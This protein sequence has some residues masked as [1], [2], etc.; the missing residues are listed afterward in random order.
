MAGMGRNVFIFQNVSV[1]ETTSKA[2]FHMSWQ[3]NIK[4]KT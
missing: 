3:Y 1:Y 2:G 4:Q